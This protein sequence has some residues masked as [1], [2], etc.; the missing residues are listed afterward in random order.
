MM[1]H[2]MIFRWVYERAKNYNL[3]VLD[4]NDYHD[5]GDEQEVQDPEVLLKQ[6]KHATWLYVLLLLGES[7]ETLSFAFEY[8][9]S[10][11]LCSFL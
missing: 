10:S 6:Q 5:D 8:C 1:N 3:F 11:I 4:E 9:T 7:G 2:N